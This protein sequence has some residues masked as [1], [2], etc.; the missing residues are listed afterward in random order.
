MSTRRIDHSTAGAPATGPDTEADRPEGSSVAP[1][2]SKDRALNAERVARIAREVRTV[3][4]DFDE[5]AFVSSVMADLPTLELKAR[6]TRVAS[7]LNDHLPAGPSG[8]DALIA[9]LPPSPEAAGV[10][11]DFGLHIY[12]PHSEYAARHHLDRASLDR[13]LEALR[14]FTRYFSAEDAVRSFLNAFPD[15]TMAAVRAW[16]R[17]EDYRV[18]RL[19]S[20]STRPHLPWSAA[21]GLPA[22]TAIP[23]LDDLYGD[24]SRFVTASVANHLRDIARTQPDLVL[25]TLGRW[26]DQGGAT[27][28]EFAFIAREALRTRL[29]EGWAPAFTFLGYTPDAPLE[30]SPLRLERTE[31]QEGDTLA[32]AADLAAPAQTA[33]HVMYLIAGTTPTGRNREKAHQLAKRTTGSAALSLAKRHPLRSTANFPLSPGRYELIV[34]VNGRR[35]PSAPFRIVAAVAEA[36]AAD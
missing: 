5:Q 2:S 27:D 4:P 25:S 8:L 17:D 12:S 21:I 1:V 19:A 22:D 14:A 3:L 9:S 30:L 11:N 18:R 34:Q 33:V 7:G 23:V 29:K 10:T 28:K 24:G 6:I 35:F 26:R 32:F 16:A 13:A 15:E 36:E 31:L 20:E